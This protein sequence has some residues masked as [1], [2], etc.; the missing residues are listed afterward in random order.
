MPSDSPPPKVV[1]AERSADL[2]EPLDQWLFDGDATGGAFALNVSTLEPGEGPPMHV[3]R[4][5]DETYYVLEGC[6]EI[7]VDGR[8]ERL[9]AGDAVFLP[10]GVPHALRNPGPDHS[11]VLMLVHPPGLEGF[12]QEMAR[13]R[14]SGAATPDA[15]AA[16]VARYF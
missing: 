14:R 2:S 4:N 12:F 5:E 10:R 8:H 7:D 13:L 15:L 1:R 3:H 9:E 11:T 16:L 6:L